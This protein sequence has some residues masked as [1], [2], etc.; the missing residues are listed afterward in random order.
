[1]NGENKVKSAG[2]FMSRKQV[3]LYLAQKVRSEYYFTAH[4]NLFLEN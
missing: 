4:S 2:F 1:M 3:A